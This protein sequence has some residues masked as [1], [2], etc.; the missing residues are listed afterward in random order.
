MTQIEVQPPTPLDPEPVWT[1]WVVNVVAPLLA[2]GAVASE[3]AVYAG[4]LPRLGA[5]RE[6]AGLNFV[7]ATLMPMLTLWGA[8]RLGERLDRYPPRSHQPPGRV[9]SVI[10]VAIGLPVILVFVVCGLLWVWCILI[11]IVIVRSF[12]AGHHVSGNWP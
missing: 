9:Q 11:G 12:I 1:R 3:V 7:F 5:F 4:V 8:L 2:V 10:N 6:R